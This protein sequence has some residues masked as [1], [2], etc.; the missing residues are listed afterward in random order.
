MTN[1][2]HGSCNGLGGFDLDSPGHSQLGD[3]VQPEVH[4]V[5]EHVDVEPA[6]NVHQETGHGPQQHAVQDQEQAAKDP[7]T[8]R[9]TLL[10][11]R[12]R[13]KEEIARARQE[14]RRRENARR[15]EGQRRE[16]ERKL[17][18]RRKAEEEE[19][20]AVAAAT[21]AARAQSES[22]EH[23]NRDRDEPA[24]DS[25]MKRREANERKA[26]AAAVVAAATAKVDAQTAVGPLEHDSGAAHLVITEEEHS[27][28]HLME[29]LMTS[30]AMCIITPPSPPITP[31][32]TTSPPSGYGDGIISS[33]CEDLQT[34]V[35]SNYLFDP[36][37]RW[38]TVPTRTPLP[39]EERAQTCE[40]AT[41]V[42]FER[43]GGGGCSTSTGPVIPTTPK[44][45][46][47]HAAPEGRAPKNGVS[48]T[49]RNAHESKE[50]VVEAGVAI[51]AEE[52]V[53][54]DPRDATQRHGLVRVSDKR[55]FGTV[56]GPIVTFTPS[57]WGFIL[58]RF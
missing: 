17:E 35:E 51:G 7:D 4:E 43:S 33:L 34:G 2:V 6:H 26:G 57:T 30:A 46:I 1:G 56:R 18:A 12:R 40:V 48:R 27:E 50:S 38:T 10:S 32:R 20:A 14:K 39:P 54:V 24:E 3:R 13:K 55:E 21:A 45:K 15:L 29:H 58:V 25:V 41:D 37:L 47:C 44:V 9:D 36:P 23:S 49:T 28:S 53:E 5:Q 11:M 31:R 52:A 8:E 42:L 19:A 22:G 16:N